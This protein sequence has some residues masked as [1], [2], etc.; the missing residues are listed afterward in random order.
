M[1]RRRFDPRREQEGAGSVL[2]RGLRR[3]PRQVRSGSVGRLCCRRGRPRTSRTRSRCGA[4]ASGRGRRPRPVRRRCWRARSGRRTGARLGGHCAHPAVEEP[5]ASANQAACAARARSASPA[6]VMASSA[7]ARML[8]S[9]RYRT[10][11]P[12]LA[13][14]EQARRRAVVIDDHQR[15]ARQPADHV[16]RGGCRHVEG[17]EDEL[18]RRQGCATCERGQR[19]QAALVVGEQQVVAPRRWSTAATGGVPVCGW[20]GRPGPG[21]GRRGAG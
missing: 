3:R 8:S 14:I 19:P 16:D 11:W 2:D 10:G 5:A 4:P 13:R 17:F 15:S 20:S 18:H 7:N 1:T 6:S 12:A 9:S 21:T